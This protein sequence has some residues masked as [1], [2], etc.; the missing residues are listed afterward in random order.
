MDECLFEKVICK[1]WYT[2]C[3]NAWK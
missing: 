2:T 3:R 1:L